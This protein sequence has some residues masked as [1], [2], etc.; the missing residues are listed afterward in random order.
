MMPYLQ[1]KERTDDERLCEGAESGEES[2]QVRYV[3][4]NELLL[5]FEQQTVMQTDEYTLQ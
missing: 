3:I 1:E 4:D 5:M 2:I